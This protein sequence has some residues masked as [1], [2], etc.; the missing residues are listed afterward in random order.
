MAPTAV[1]RQHRRWANQAEAAEHI[2]VSPRT[3][4]KY[5]AAGLVPAHRIGR[6][7]RFDLNEVD[8]SLQRVP[9]AR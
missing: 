2:G 1:E 7:I 9:T 4:R 6:M 3:L 8:D 5:V